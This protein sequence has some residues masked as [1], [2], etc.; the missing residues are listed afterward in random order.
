MLF[1]DIKAHLFLDTYYLIPTTSLLNSLIPQIRLRPSKAK[2]IS[3]I[4][5]FLTGTQII[6]LQLCIKTPNIRVGTLILNRTTV[7]LKKQNPIICN[8]IMNSFK[9]ASI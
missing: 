9:K 5:K 6:I 7:L 8:L 2:L 4:R 1:L 3:L